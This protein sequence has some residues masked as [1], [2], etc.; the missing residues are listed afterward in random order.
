MM[1][2]ILLIIVPVLLLLFF[3]SKQKGGIFATKESKTDLSD[4][5]NRGTLVIATSN[6]ASDYFLYKGEPQGFQLEVLEDLGTY[7]G[8]KV[9][10][11]VC[12]NPT[13][14]LEYLRCGK[15]DMVASSWNLTKT[16]ED[17]LSYSM[18]LLE[19]NML[20]VQRN[21]PKSNIERAI[22]RKSL[23]K[24]FKELYGSS[25]YVPM[26]SLQTDLVRLY[27]KI[28]VV[29]MPQYSQENLIELVANGKVD[30]TVCNSILAD[31]L[32]TNFPTLD[33]STVVKRAE[34]IA[35]LFRRSSAGLNEKVNLWMRA[36]KKSTRYSL[37]LDKYFNYQNR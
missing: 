6:N 7:L 26:M 30:Y 15:C 12:N 25:V 5:E 34:P 36:Y 37:L 19:S 29:E 21:L 3:I 4:I 9:E 18:P 27:N 14:I 8:L 28:H 23:V 33:F 24:N 11:L 20:L 10:L 31:R 1:K 13:E 17:F 22:V 2:K 35:W 16:S 32:K